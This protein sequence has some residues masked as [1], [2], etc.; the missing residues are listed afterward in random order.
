MRGFI[1]RCGLKGWTNTKF[2]RFWTHVGRHPSTLQT[3]LFAGIS[4]LKSKELLYFLSSPIILNILST[5]VTIL[6]T[7]CLFDYRCPNPDDGTVEL[8]ENGI[9]TVS[10]FSFKMFTFTNSSSIFIHCNVHLC[11]LRNNNCTAVS[12]NN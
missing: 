11:L 6:L 5:Y 4:L 9:S 1:L 3:T 10:R 2:L 12:T 7:F 8:V